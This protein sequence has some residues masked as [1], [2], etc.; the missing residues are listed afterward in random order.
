MNRGMTD[1]APMHRAYRASGR[2][3]N[4]G[5][6]MTNNRFTT[7]NAR[8][9]AY[10]T[11]LRAPVRTGTTRAAGYRNTVNNSRNATLTFIILLS[12]IVALL[13]LAIYAL[14]RRPDHNDHRVSD[15][16]SASRRR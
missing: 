11:G 15:H 4:A 3:Y 12:V 2:N 9:P 16:E 1:S 6:N 5:N 7:D 13:A 14:M 10:R 8:T